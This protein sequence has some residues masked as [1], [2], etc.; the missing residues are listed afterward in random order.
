MLLVSV[1]NFAAVRIYGESEFWL[2]GGKVILIFLLFAFTFITMVGGNPQHDAYGFRYWTDPGAFAQFRST[3]DLGRFEG[4]L[5]C[6]WSAAFTVV[7]PEFISM[8]A[9]EA[10]HPSVYMKAAFK[11]VYYRFGIFFIFGAL[12]VSIVIPYNNPK[13]VELWF[14]S[15]SGSGS[16]AGSPYVI[17]MGLLGINVL[18]HVVNALILTSIF[19][20]GNTYVYCATRILHGLSIDGRAPGFLSYTNKRGVPVYCF[21]VVMLF[22]LLSFLQVSK[23]SAKALAYLTS[24]ITGACQINYIVMT[25]TFLRYYKACKVQGL[26]RRSRPYY[27]RFQPYGAWIALTTQL[28]IVTCMGYTSFRPWSVEDFFTNYTMQIAAPVL[29]VGWK[30][31]KK[32]HVVRAQDVD[33]VWERPIVDEYE[34]SSTV[35]VVGFWT[36]VLQLLGLRKGT[37]TQDV[38]A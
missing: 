14:G 29:F 15:G 11:T 28:A 16:A 36:E 2:S 24:L 5:S 12:A 13:L 1:L 7:G 10:Q 26:D 18:P 9:A 19:S 34:R 8:I 31:Y 22:S 25:I 23:G 6:L 35:P 17:A 27:G 37:G 30:L 38:D 33:L 20:A 21:C 32:T 4:F 3:G